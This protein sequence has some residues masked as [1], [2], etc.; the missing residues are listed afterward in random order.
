MPAMQL[1]LHMEGGETAVPVGAA[2]GAVTSVGIRLSAGAAAEVLIT[3]AEGTVAVASQ[4]PLEAMGADMVLVWSVHGTNNL[5]SI[6]HII[7]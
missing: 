2:L 1:G 3:M 7:K 5:T 4:L 6:S